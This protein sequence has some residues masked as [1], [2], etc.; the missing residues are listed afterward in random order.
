M[1]TTVRLHR[2]RWDQVVAYLKSEGGANHDRADILAAAVARR[3]VGQ[4]GGVP[5]RFDDNTYPFIIIAIDFALG[6]SD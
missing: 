4:R 6:L 3:D 5:V 2:W 1:G